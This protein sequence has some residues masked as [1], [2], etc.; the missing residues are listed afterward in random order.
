MNKPIKLKIY[1]SNNSFEEEEKFINF[2][3]FFFNDIGD[4]NVP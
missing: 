4:L 2:F 1:S 3:F